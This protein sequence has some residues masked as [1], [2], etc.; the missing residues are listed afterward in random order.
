MNPFERLTEKL[1]EKMLDAMSD[2]QQRQSDEKVAAEA[3]PAP[4]PAPLTADEMA[5][6]EKRRLQVRNRFVLPAVAVLMVAC[7]SFYSGTIGIPATLFAAGFVLWVVAN[8]LF[9]CPRCGAPLLGRAEK[10]THCHK[11]GVQL[12]PQG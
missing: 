8:R 3:A 12:K 2:A 7:A 5:A 10:K 4:P 9:V 6:L 11:C 1:S